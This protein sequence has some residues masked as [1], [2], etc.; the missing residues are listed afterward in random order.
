MAANFGEM[1]GYAQTELWSWQIKRA[2]YLVDHKETTGVADM[3]AQLP[4]ESQKRDDVIALRIRAAAATGTLAAALSKYDDPARMQALRYAA[5][6]LTKDGDTASARRVLELVYTSELK[7]DKFDASNFLGLAEI[8][9][10]E[11]DVAG[12]VALL[13]R[14]SLISGNPFSILDPA[15]ALLEKTGHV[16]EAAPF[17]ADLAKAEP[18]NWNARGQFAAATG[19][20]DELTAVAK[21][22][23]ASYT[24]RATA[25]LGL[26]KLK[27]AALVGVDGELVLLSSQDAL[28]EAAVSKPFYLAARLEAARANGVAA[29]VRVKLLSGAIAIDIREQEARS[30][31]FRA[32]LEA[33]QD[34]LVIALAGQVIPQYMMN[35]AD[36]APWM[37][38][39]FAADL[40]LPERIAIARFGR[41][42]TA[43][44][45]FEDGT[46][47]LSDRPTFAA[48]ACDST[49]HW[50][51]SCAE[52]N[53]REEQCP[54]ADGLGQSGSG[55]A[56]SSEGG[57]AMKKRIVIAG[58]VVLAA[59]VYWAIAQ[60]AAQ[61]LAA[62]FPTGALLYLE[63]KDFS[64]LIGDWDGSAEKA[65][66]LK[67]ANHDVFS[68]SALY[69][70]LGQAQSD[71]ATAAGIPTDYA[72]LKSLAG[73][74][75]ALAIYNVGALQFLYAT[76]LPSGRALNTALWKARGSYQTRKAGGVDF[77]VKED[78]PTKR[79][80]AFAYA[81]DLLL[82]ATRED[83]IAGALELLAS[84][85]RPSLRSEDWFA[86]ALQCGWRGHGGFAIG[87]QC[88]ATGADSALQIALGAG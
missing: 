78:A 38:E 29:A 80:A 69:Q 62:V 52:G 20:V 73:T 49:K 6:E 83:L 3:L 66:W 84:T 42:A 87:A 59:V 65:A 14:A 12:A 58:T 43:I 50:Y 19:A 76:H 11:R 26:R 77:Y 70:K 61:P 35:E 72:L 54:A 24:A 9:I 86:N 13:R 60:P 88:R 56:G 7:A 25:A 79:V 71:F 21:S 5:A 31:L 68:Q 32:A 37:A 67:S 57:G 16:A 39:Q 8:R 82:L 2:A 4:E 48:R 41:C 47:G 15:A 30:A 18:W 33:R 46:N 36:F 10:E 81:G 1:R 53:G 55:P 51:D 28:T 34:G 40:K 22:R 64:S 27:A 75:S 63:A 23:E 44:W 85:G 74:N 45:R 17:L